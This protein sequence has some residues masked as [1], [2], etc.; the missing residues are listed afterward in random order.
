MSP[1]STSPAWPRRATTTAYLGDRRRCAS[2]SK[3]W[4]RSTMTCVH[5]SPNG[6][7]L[8]Y[9]Q[10]DLTAAPSGRMPVGSA[11]FDIIIR[12]PEIDEEKLD[13]RTTW[14]NSGRLQRK[15]RTISSAPRALRGRATAGIVASFSGTSFGDV[16]LVPAPALKNP[17][18]IRDVAE[19]H[20]STR[21]RRGYI[22]C[23]FERQCEIAL[24][25]LARIHARNGDATDCMYV[26]GKSFPSTS[27]L[28]AKPASQH[29]GTKRCFRGSDAFAT[30]ACGCGDP[31]KS[32]STFHQASSSAIGRAATAVS[33]AHDQPGRESLSLWQL[34]FAFI[35]LYMARL[36]ISSTM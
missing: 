2:L 12:Q 13:P 1:A 31:S 3:C 20:L 19:C 29:F 15:T 36:M 30:G 34:L 22:R 25:N 5:T 8:V 16:G 32:I 9:P 26:C 35:C 21:T 23:I 28:S 27:P 24:A 17:K 11:F 7:I 4:V 10:C 33:V 18:N 14:K 6:D